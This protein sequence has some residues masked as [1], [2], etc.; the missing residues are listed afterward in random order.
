[1]KALAASSIGQYEKSVSAL[2][3]YYRTVELGLGAGWFEDE[4]RAF[5][6]PFPPSVGERFDRLEEQLEIVNL[7]LVVTAAREDTMAEQW[8][9]E[10]WV[11]T[12]DMPETARDVVYD[13]PEKPLRARVLWRPSMPAGMTITGPAVI[14]EPNSTILIHPGDV[15]TVTDT[16]HLVVDLARKD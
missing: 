5:A 8:L 16:G 15:V 7:R 14:E 1:M 9:T 13:D 2:G 3:D 6:I 4:H 11:P 10:K 12:D